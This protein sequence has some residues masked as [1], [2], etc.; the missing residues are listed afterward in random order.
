MELFAYFKYLFT[1]WVWLISGL[2]IGGVIAASLAISAPDAYLATVSIYVQKEA[3]PPNTNYFTYEGYYA[4]QTAAAYAETA[5]KLLANDEIVKRAAES[6]NLPTDIASIASLKGGITSKMEA[7]QLIQIE[8]VM[9]NR[10]QAAG[11][12][13]GLSQAVRTRT[14]EINK[15]GD[16]SLTIEQINEEPYVVLVRPL[17]PLYATVG[18]IAGLLLASIAA[19]F[20]TY[21][22][23]H[24]A[25]EKK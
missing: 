22:R 3:A 12:A 18:A 14:A 16:A 4:Q 6:A 2:I 7:P 21:W 15:T 20:W 8:V 5:L 25:K 24:D 17:V 11:L 13:E 23:H 9:P 10:D 19:A 1:Y